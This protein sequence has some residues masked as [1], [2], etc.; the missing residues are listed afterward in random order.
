MEFAEKLYL[1]EGF[2]RKRFSYRRNPIVYMYIYSLL[3][4]LSFRV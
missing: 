1:A 2:F 3:Q 4:I